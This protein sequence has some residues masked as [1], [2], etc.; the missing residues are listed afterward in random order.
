MI[1]NDRTDDLAN[2][3]YDRLKDKEEDFKKLKWTKTDW[4][5]AMAKK[6]YEDYEYMRGN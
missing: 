5:Y 4:S 6:Q 1:F 3:I 2:D